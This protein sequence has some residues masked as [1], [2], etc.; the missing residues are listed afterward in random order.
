MK[1]YM[2]P[3]TDI[4]VMETVNSIAAGSLTGRVEEG[5]DLGDA[6]TTNA[7]SG[8]YSRRNSIWDDD[9]DF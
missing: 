6:P 3:T 2:Q 9:S 1:K 7:T 8:N 4:I 5:Q